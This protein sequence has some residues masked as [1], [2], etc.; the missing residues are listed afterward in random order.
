YPF[1][2]DGSVT[3]AAGTVHTFLANSEGTRLQFG[4]THV[5]LMVSLEGK[6]DDGM[7]L[8]R[9][10]SFDARDFSG[11]PHDEVVVATIN[12]LAKEL[13]ALRT[14]PLAEPF[15]GPAILRNRASG[16]FFHEIFGHRIEGHRQKLSDEGQTFARKVGEPILPSFLSVVD[17]PSLPALGK[18]DLNGYYPFDDEGMPSRRVSLVEHGVLKEFLLSRSPLPGFPHSNAH[19]RR[20]PGREPVSRQGNLMVESSKQVPF[21][22]L[23]RML[24]E[25]CRRQNK[26]YGLIFD[27][28]S[29]GYTTTT[30]SGPQASKVLPP[31]V[32]RV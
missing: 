13:A 7:A 4:R 16:V 20:Q 24:I 18:Q 10:E 25:E 3:L 9:Y 19:G 28:I 22:Q 1:V 31:M 27:D 12:R 6:A 11:L 5:R 30:R 8:Q 15:T 26:P 2:L 17:D 23:R 29:G 14:A 21:A 32:T